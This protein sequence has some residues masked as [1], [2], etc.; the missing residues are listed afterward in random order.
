LLVEWRGEDSYSL[1][2]LP[3][4]LHLFGCGMGLAVLSAWQ[5]APREEPLLPGLGRRPWAWWALAA[6]AYWAVVN[7][8]G[9]DFKYLPSTAGQWVFRDLM[10]AIVATSLLVPGVFGRQDE[11]LIRRFLNLRPVQLVG[12]VS[13]GIY[14]WH[15]AAIQL[16]QDAFDRPMFTGPFLQLLIAATTLSLLLAGASYVIVERPALRFKDGRPRRRV[17]ATSPANA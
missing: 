4:Y 9:F 2:T 14:L 13:Y 6:V 17:P 15:E 11:G 7:Y 16:V 3:V 8:A 5:S 1:T 12:L 10:M